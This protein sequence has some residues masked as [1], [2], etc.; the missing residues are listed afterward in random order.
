MKYTY[1]LMIAVML[2]TACG[3]LTNDPDIFQSEKL[4]GKYKVDLTPFV[5]EAVK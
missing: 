4:K 5:A 1:I 3:N 2:F